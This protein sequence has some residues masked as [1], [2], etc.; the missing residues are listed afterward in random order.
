MNRND[1]LT[2]AQ[3]IINGA[4]QESY[5]DALK[6]FQLIANLWGSYLN[7][8]ITPK[9]VADMMIL[10]KIARNQNQTKEDNYIDICGYAALGAEVS[11]NNAFK[12]NGTSLKEAKR[13]NKNLN[14][15]DELHEFFDP[16][17]DKLKD[18]EVEWC[19]NEFDNKIYCVTNKNTFKYNGSSMIVVL[20]K[21]K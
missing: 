5:G 6:N 2:Q 19:F 14:S 11:N 4:R 7:T 16:I 15:S 17:M 20:E 18:T 9:Q 13:F 21:E 3:T 10:L 8:T 12:N 1:I